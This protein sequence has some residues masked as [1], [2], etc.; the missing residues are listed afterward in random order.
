[1][2]A[3]CGGE[4]ECIAVGGHGDGEVRLER[5]A[6]RDL[7]LPLAE[8]GL[9]V[10]DRGGGPRV[11]ALLIGGLFFA[12]ELHLEPADVQ[13]AGLRQEGFVLPAGIER[14][15]GDLE[16]RGAGAGGE[17]DLPHER[18][19]RPSA[20][21]HERHHEPGEQPIRMAGEVLPDDLNDEARRRACSKSRTRPPWRTTSGRRRRRSA[22]DRPAARRGCRRPRRSA[23][24]RA[25]RA[26]RA[27][28]S[29]PAVPSRSPFARP[30]PAARSTPGFARRARSGRSRRSRSARSGSRSRPRPTS[31]ASRLRPAARGPAANRGRPR[32]SPPAPDRAPRRRACRTSASRCVAGRV[33]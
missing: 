3:L 19:D 11:G 20:G 25:A 15:L 7:E 2:T 1:M 31:R 5:A 26:G 28:G 8:H 17:Q 12:H 33:S 16:Q 18:E 9:A 13:P 24:R 14:V 29:C 22:G 32:R 30:R 6:R 21:Q 27:G 23:A 4:N 10:D